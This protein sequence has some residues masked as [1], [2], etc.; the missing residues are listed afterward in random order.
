MSQEVGEEIGS[1]LGKF[2]EVDRRS[3]QFDLAKFMRVRVE[4]E[5]D[6]PLRRWAYIASSD[7][8]WLWLTFKYERLPTVCFIYGKLGHDKKHCPTFDVW[9]TAYHQYGDWLRA[10]WTAKVAAK[11]RNSSMDRI[12]VVFDEL[13][14]QQNTWPTTGFASAC[15]EASGL[16]G[17]KWSLEKGDTW[18]SDNT[19]C[20]DGQLVGK[21]QVFNGSTKQMMSEAVRQDLSVLGSCEKSR[22][23]IRQDISI[24][25]RGSFSHGPKSPTSQGPKGSISQGSPSTKAP[26]DKNEKDNPMKKNATIAVQASVIF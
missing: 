23:H 21:V 7:G 22:D 8:E 24:E 6:K 9:Q 4:L 15:L 20:A 19:T 3:W 13:E 14:V 17:G 1:K 25:H 12:R 10:G 18:G 11:E 26:V 2:I 16:K 5:I